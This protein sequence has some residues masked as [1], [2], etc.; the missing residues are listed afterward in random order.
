M[1]Y[2]INVEEWENK[3]S[4]SFNVLL[5]AKRLGKENN[6]MYVF[7]ISS[8]YFKNSKEMFNPKKRID[9][10]VAHDKDEAIKTWGKWKGLINK[11][12]KISP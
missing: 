3:L 8:D 7:K 4:R 10:V 9:Y 2:T 1:S 5:Y 11:I 6:G 12:E